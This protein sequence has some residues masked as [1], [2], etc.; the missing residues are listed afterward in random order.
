MALD[1]AQNIGRLD[2]KVRETLA[3]GLRDPN[4]PAD[5]LAGQNTREVRGAIIE[6]LNA[7]RSHGQGQHP[8]LD[9]ETATYS[10][11]N[12]A[13]QARGMGRQAA[14][15][16]TESPQ[17]EAPLPREER[18]AAMLEGMDRAQQRMEIERAIHQGRER[19]G[20]APGVVEIHG[21]DAEGLAA[22]AAAMRQAGVVAG[23]APEPEAIVSPNTPL[24]IGGR[25]I[26]QGFS[27]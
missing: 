18:T 1:N 13:M 20:V 24:R 11:I 8:L 3:R 27:G 5:G 25:D 4:N 17:A 26:A 12:S 19:R 15:P 10:Q 22:A 9:P 23:N 16:R 6:Y 21:G 2:G 14:G 7:N